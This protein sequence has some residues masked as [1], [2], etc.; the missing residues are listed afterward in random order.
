[1]FKKDY[2]FEALQVCGRILHFYQIRITRKEAKVYAKYLIGQYNCK[3][4]EY[5]TMGKII[6]EKRTT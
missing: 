6:R 2:H 5:Y 4:V 1:M 3:I